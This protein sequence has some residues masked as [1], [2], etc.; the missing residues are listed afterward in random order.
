V[1][2]V[3]EYVS[4]YLHP[5][6]GGLEAVHLPIS[7]L[8]PGEP[9]ALG[10]YE[11]EFVTM[12]N[13]CAVKASRSFS[14]WRAH[15]RCPLRGRAGLGHH[16]GRSRRARRARQHR[17][18]GPFENIDDLLRR[19]RVLLVPSLWAEARSRIVVERSP[20]RVPVLAANLGGIPEA[21]C[22]V[23]DTLLPWN[24][25][26]GYRAALDENFVPV[27]EVPRKTPRRGERRCGRL[28]DD[29]VA[30][31]ELAE[32]GR[33]A[34][35]AYL[36]KLGPEPFEH[37]LRGRMRGA[38]AQSRAR[39][40]RGPAP[41]ARVAPPP[42]RASSIPGSRNFLQR[43]LRLLRFPWPARVLMR[44]HPGGE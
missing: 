19:T 31:D 35:L 38:E 13:P 1:V 36:R 28:L 27:A 14:S 7:L 5:R 2:G 23:A 34:A 40:L 33:A 22:G 17:D 26:S 43:Q 21:M 42:G 6:Y 3:S 30:Y 12:V 25:I 41:P 8:P 11:N 32:R 15:S 37:F 29:R 24:P 9:P 20:A 16:E 4:A 10:A 18:R 39:T 44:W